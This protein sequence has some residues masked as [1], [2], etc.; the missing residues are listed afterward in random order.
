MLKYGGQVERISHKRCYTVLQQKQTKKHF[1][2]DEYHFCFHLFILFV[3]DSK[4]KKKG[5]IYIP[6]CCAKLLH[7]TC[8]YTIKSIDNWLI[9]VGFFFK[10]LH[11]I[12]SWSTSV[13]MFCNNVYLPLYST[14]L[15][16]IVI[17]VMR[18]VVIDP[19]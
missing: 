16:H 19:Y 9:P 15:I 7:S 11:V 12:V 6:K 5:K 10:G 2:C 4:A 14:P 1:C 8:I 17:E 13:L 18:E 3:C